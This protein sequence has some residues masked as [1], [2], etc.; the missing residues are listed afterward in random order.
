MKREKHIIQ[1]A[2]GFHSWK[3]SCSECAIK[4]V[5]VAKDECARADSEIRHQKLKAV[6]GTMNI[7]SVFPVD[8]NRVA[9]KISSCFCDGCFV[10]GKFRQNCP[11][12]EEHVVRLQDD[13]E[14]PSVYN[15]ESRE[16]GVRNGME[17]D[18]DSLYQVEIVFEV[19]DHVAAIYCDDNQQ[20]NL[21]FVGQVKDESDDELYISF[22]S[23]TNVRGNITFRWP[24]PADEIWIK[25]PGV[26]CKVEEPKARGK[27]RRIFVIESVDEI[28][29]QFKKRK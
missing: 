1:D 29:E 18:G 7:H 12:W 6:K 19:G 4:F 9:T 21:W 15:Q 8:E 23:M 14:T 22:M 27:N 25:R 13:T 17:L 3:N 2:Q 16:D 28:E 20:Q 26:L 11:G 10:A 5:F 24:Q